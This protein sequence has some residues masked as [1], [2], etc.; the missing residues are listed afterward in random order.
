MVSTS[1]YFATEG[2]D[3]NYLGEF[4]NVF[5]KANLLLDAKFTSPNYSINFFGYGN[6]TLNNE[7]DEDDGV[8]VNLDYNRVR[9]RTFKVAPALQWRGHLGSKVKLGLSYETIEIEKTEGRYINTFIGDNTEVEDKFVGAELAY[10]FE[11]RDNEA[12]PTLG[13]ETNLQ[14]G[15]KSNID[16]SEGFGYIIPSLAFDY[17][18][19]AS[20]QLVLATKLAGHINL[21]D[22]FLFYQAANLGANN[23]LRGYRNE[24][25]TG[26]SS[27]YQ[28][29]DLR[30]NL[31]KART[32]LVP[33]TIGV[34]GDVD[35]GR[36]WVDDSLVSDSSYNSDGLNTSIGGG[37][38]INAVDMM[39]FNVSAFSS[40]D[41]MRLAFKLGFGF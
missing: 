9:L 11:S 27:F 25:F 17:K 26:K 23:G 36:V 24:R 19:T 37:I 39:S 33:I 5:G 12:F 28:S 20:G 22:D 21:G 30:L 1:Y 35:Y 10:G 18:L 8:D 32:S 34:Y 4:A 3:L 41:G 15:Y 38:F 16:N 29:T 7:A 13:M 31:H 40:D 14:V 6:S 2:Y